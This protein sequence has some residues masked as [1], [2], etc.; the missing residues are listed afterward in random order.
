MSVEPQPF[1]QS[2]A[3]ANS[4]IEKWR[5]N[6]A[7]ARYAGPM[8]DQLPEIENRHD[9]DMIDYRACDSTVKI[10]QAIYLRLPPHARERFDG[11]GTTLSHSAPSP[12][13][14]IHHP[15]PLLPD[16]LAL[17]Q[18]RLERY[19]QDQL[20]RD[21]WNTATHLVRP[22]LP[23]FTSTGRIGDTG[24][25]QKPARAPSAAKKP[26]ALHTMAITQLSKPH[27]S[28]SPRADS[29]VAAGK[30][31]TF[32]YEA[33]SEI[34]EKINDALAEQI[35]DM[36]GVPILTPAVATLRPEN[37][38]SYAQRDARRAEALARLCGQD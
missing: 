19:E 9:A 25:V 3:E 13:H 31:A 36:L 16:F 22:N 1:I 38:D 18:Q 35:S 8:L 2:S 10:P 23:T 30:P 32:T 34:G 12:W 26:L 15:Q 24:R 33:V 37:P 29:A 11:V 6:I 5:Q 27:L 4:K 20:R 17:G 21:E 7:D 14:E 28:A